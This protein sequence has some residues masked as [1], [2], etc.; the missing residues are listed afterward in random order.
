MEIELFFNFSSHGHLYSKIL[1]PGVLYW[2]VRQQYDYGASVQ[3]RLKINVT[4]TWI[5]I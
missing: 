4:S 2:F 3:C 1:Y 5:E